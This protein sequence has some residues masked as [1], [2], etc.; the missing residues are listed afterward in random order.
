MRTGW[1]TGCGQEIPSYLGADDVDSR[2]L[3]RVLSRLVVFLH[4][5]GC[6]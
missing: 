1:T 4:L 5:P 2:V 6:P 3:L